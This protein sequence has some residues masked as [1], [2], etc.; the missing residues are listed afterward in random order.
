MYVCTGL[1]IRD[2]RFWYVCLFVDSL[3]LLLSLLLTLR[4]RRGS[5]LDL[6]APGVATKAAIGD[7]DAILAVLTSC[8]IGLDSSEKSLVRELL[9]L[10]LLADTPSSILAAL[11]RRSDCYQGI[12]VS[13][14]NYSNSFT[15][16]GADWIGSRRGFS[17]DSM[18]QFTHVEYATSK[19]GNWEPLE[20]LPRD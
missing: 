1:P 12:H 2:F 17:A 18:W 13:C 14:G 7:C 10:S 19:D 9:V 4:R 6:C 8:S 11:N 15:A 5:H 16:A 3:L 20:G